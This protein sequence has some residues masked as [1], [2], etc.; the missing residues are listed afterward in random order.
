MA[1]S[2]VPEILLN[3]RIANQLFVQVKPF[4][5]HTAHTACTYPIAAEWEAW[6]QWSE[7]SASCGQ[8]SKIRTRECSEPAADNIELCDG[9]AL[10]LED[11]EAMECP[12]KFTCFDNVLFSKHACLRSKSFILQPPWDQLSTLKLAQLR[13]PQQ[14]QQLLQLQQQ[15]QQQPQLLLLLSLLPL[16]SQRLERISIFFMKF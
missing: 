1:P 3:L 9:N 7:C 16:R 14:Q 8:G 15:K 5:S 13:R 6:G 10:E 2:S 12:S 11:C 4:F